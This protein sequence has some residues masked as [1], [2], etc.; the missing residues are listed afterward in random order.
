[1]H[2]Y[3]R[4][5][6]DY[7]SKAGRLSMLQHG[8][9][10]LLIDAC[11]DRE[12]FPTREEAIDWCWASTPEEV[13]AVEFVLARF[14]TLENGV[15]VQSRIAEEIEKY[16]E[17]SETNRRI[18]V[19]REQA[20]RHGL[21][22]NVYETSPELHES[23][24]NHKPITTNQEPLTTRENAPPDGVAGKREK[25]NRGTRLPPDWQP[26]LEWTR[27]QGLQSPD[28]ELAKFRDYWSAQPGQKGV[29]QDWQATWRNW[30][31][32]AIERQPT[33]VTRPS[34]QPDVSAL[35]QAADNR[36]SR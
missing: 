27:E 19:E 35:L 1:M 5:I 14:F 23:P 25:A 34:N 28:L 17:K 10:N 13:Q 32:R 30:V 31:R 29:K 2:Y 11:Y 18:A 15:Y 7:H 22:R 6:G 8:A 21:A 9:Y 16:K 24:P 3:K 26:D 20:R 36:A 12:R 4:H 33:L